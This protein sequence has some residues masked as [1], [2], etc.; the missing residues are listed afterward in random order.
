MNKYRNK[1]VEYQGIKFDSTKE[2]NYYL[3]LKDRERKGEIYDLKLQSEYELQPAYE[4][5]GKKIRPIIYR[6]D[7]VYMERLNGDIPMAK[8]VV[9]DVKPSKTYQTPEYKLKKKMMGYV[10]GIEIKELY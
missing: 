9:A 7:F 10:Y 1:K 5:N 6:A 2:K 4:L 8:E 3:I